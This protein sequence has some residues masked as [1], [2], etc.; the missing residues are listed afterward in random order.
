VKITKPGLY[1]T[2]MSKESTNIKH[3][4]LR[5]P[6]GIFIKVIRRSN[7]CL[8]GISYNVT[9]DCPVKCI[10]EYPDDR[11]LRLVKECNDD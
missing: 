7:G 1:K 3:H 11:Q 6:E 4:G 8:E 9:S 5:V 2:I 10:K